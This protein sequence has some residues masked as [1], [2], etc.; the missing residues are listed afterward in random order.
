MIIRVIMAISMINDK[1]NQMIRQMIRDNQSRRLTQ[2]VNKL[3]DDFPFQF[4]AL[5]F[6]CNQSDDEC[7][8]TVNLWEFL[9]YYE[10]PYCPYIPNYQFSSQFKL[11]WNNFN[12][13]NSHDFHARYGIMSIIQKVFISMP[14]RNNFNDFNNPNFYAKVE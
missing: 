1:D 13:F 11:R 2:L 4:Q 5:N 3:V 9:N 12:N 7:V 14:R 8:Q 10:T 6:Y